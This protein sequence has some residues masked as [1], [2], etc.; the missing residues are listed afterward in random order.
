MTRAQTIQSLTVQETILNVLNA[1][2]ADLERR[3]PWVI[4][5]ERDEVNASLESI[6]R[7]LRFAYQLA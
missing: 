7:A 1:Q 6:N 5:D 3:L 4:G 2:R